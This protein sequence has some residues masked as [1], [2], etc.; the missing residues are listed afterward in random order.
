VNR[1]CTLQDIG[2]VGGKKKTD[3]WEAGTSAPAIAMLTERR[4]MGRGVEACGSAADHLC[5]PRISALVST[6]YA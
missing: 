1:A 2:L 3:S 5:N 4:R 6:V